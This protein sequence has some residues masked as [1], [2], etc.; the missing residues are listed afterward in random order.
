M[1]PFLAAVPAWYQ[2][3]TY[4]LLIYLNVVV[5]YTL[6]CANIYEWPSISYALFTIYRTII[7]K[8]GLSALVRGSVLRMKKSYKYGLRAIIR[9]YWLDLPPYSSFWQ[10]CSSQPCRPFYSC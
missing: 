8:K 2:L 5:Y 3:H 6:T 1:P 4:V 7:M 10:D 9:A